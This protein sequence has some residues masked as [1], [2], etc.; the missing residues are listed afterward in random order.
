M[1]Q[2]SPAFLQQGPHL[3][4]FSHSS[5]FDAQKFLSERNS[6]V[7]HSGNNQNVTSAKSCLTKH[8]K[9]QTYREA[10]SLPL[11][12]GLHMCTLL[13]SFHLLYISS[14][15]S[16]SHLIFPLIV[17]VSSYCPFTSPFILHFNPSLAI[18]SDTAPTVLTVFD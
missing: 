8:N 4:C 6:L 16:F 15:C 9:D 11:T 12:F 14:S 18:S 13:V 17:M 5:H 1:E 7:L 10:T 3:L 2:G